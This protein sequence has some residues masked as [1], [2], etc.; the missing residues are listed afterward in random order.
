[1]KIKLDN[2]EKTILESY[3]NEEWVEIPEMKNEIEKHVEYSNNALKKNKRINIRLN[4]RD[5]ELIK[6]NAIEQGLPYQTLISSLIHKYVTG[7]LVEKN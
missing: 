3:E 7:K 2:E 5:L 6:R 4:A 1:M